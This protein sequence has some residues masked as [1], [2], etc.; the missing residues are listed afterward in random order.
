MYVKIRV[1]DK[2]SIAILDSGVMNTF[3]AD[4]LVA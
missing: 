3:V 1:N 4:K 2:E